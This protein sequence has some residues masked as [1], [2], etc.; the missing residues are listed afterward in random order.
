L[1]HLW[2]LTTGQKAD[3]GGAETL[4][5]RKQFASTVEELLSEELLSEEL[6]SEELLSEEL[7]SGVWC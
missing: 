2:K 4:K 7:L 5:T 6:L 3:S 1:P